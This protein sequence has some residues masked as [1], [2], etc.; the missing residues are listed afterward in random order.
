MDIEKLTD[1]QNAPVQG[2]G[3][4]GRKLALALL[5]ERKNEC[6]EA[7]PILLC[8]DEVVV[9][10]EAEQ[11]A[12]ANALLE[13]AMIEGMNAVLNSMNEV[14]IPVEVDA[15]IVRSWREGG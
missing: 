2:T 7:V 5:W 9:E 4:D 13:T 12:S 14:R 1:R 10:C 3:A 8:H 11:A 15:R 6:L